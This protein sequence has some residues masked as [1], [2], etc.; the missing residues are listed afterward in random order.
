MTRGDRVADPRE[1]LAC[2][3]QWNPAA[4]RHYPGFVLPRLAQADRT[5]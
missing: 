2:L 4:W 1:V 5:G 3:L